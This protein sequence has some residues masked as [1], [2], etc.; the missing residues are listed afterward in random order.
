M[1]S[2]DELRRFHEER[3]RVEETEEPA[4]D[5]EQEE[6]VPDEDAVR[7]AQRRFSDELDDAD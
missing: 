5:H 1:R 4:P 3:R 2:K 7:E 6:E